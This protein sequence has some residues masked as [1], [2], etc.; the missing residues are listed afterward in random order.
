MKKTLLI[1][2]TYYPPQTGGISTLMSEIANQLGTSNVVLTRVQTIASETEYNIYR[3]NKKILASY[4]KAN[5]ISAMICIIKRKPDLII[6]ATVEDALLA[7]K[8]W[9]I[10]KIPFVVW[11]HGNEI[12]HLCNLPKPW[13]KEINALNCAKKLI[14]VSQYT[15]DKLRQLGLSEHK[16]QI[17]HPGCNENLFT[18]NGFIDT[19]DLPN[20]LASQNT[21]VLITVANLVKRKGHDMVIQSLPKI[22]KKHPHIF[23]LIVGEGRD[24]NYLK[25]LTKKYK[26]QDYV[27]FFG[28]ASLKQLITF[29]TIADVFVM[30]SRIREAQSDVEGFGIVYLEANCC[31]LPVIGGKSGGVPDAIEDGITGFL[32]DPNNSDEIAEKVCYLLD[33]PEKAK[34]MGRKGRLRVEKN[35]SWKKIGNQIKSVLSLI[36]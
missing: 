25:E 23:Y 12:V 16:L 15:R 26:V 13:G 14:A 28:K 6:C 19:S 4:H 1:S 21:K 10:L 11:A 32:V 27:I 29:Y 7:H 8:I 36:E 22:I 34:E 30:S 24:A 2:L 3:V 17:I 18:L 20:N 9:R 33:N 35:F 5:F 31:G